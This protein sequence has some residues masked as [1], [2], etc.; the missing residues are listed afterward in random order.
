MRT[1]RQDLRASVDMV[2]STV[3]SKQLLIAHEQEERSREALKLAEEQRQRNEGFMRDASII[4]CVLLLPAL[5][6]GFFGAN[7]NFPGRDDEL[8]LLY[9]LGGGRP[10]RGD[11]RAGDL[12]PLSHAEPQARPRGT[13]R[14]LTA[15]RRGRRR[16]AA[17]RARSA[18]EP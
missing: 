9:M 16:A 3:A 1:L 12:A 18:A 11:R 2:A 17:S 15:A 7:V 8:G 13:R 10:D 5:V 6:A 14:R 4:A